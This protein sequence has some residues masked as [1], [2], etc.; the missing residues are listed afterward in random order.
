[1]LNEILID[2]GVYYNISLY[3]F[4]HT[5]QVHKYLIL[6]DYNWFIPNRNKTEQYKTG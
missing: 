1:M 6:Y 2:T 5:V 4:K 3:Y